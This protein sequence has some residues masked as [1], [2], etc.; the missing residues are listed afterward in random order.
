MQTADTS[1]SLVAIEGQESGITVCGG[2]DPGMLS[3][4]PSLLSHVE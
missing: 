4:A 2:M 3:S 1:R